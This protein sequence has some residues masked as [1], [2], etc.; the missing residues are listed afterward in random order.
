MNESITLDM[1]GTMGSAKLVFPEDSEMSTYTVK[2]DV[3]FTFEVNA[4]SAD[5]AA[6]KA[7]YFQETMKHSWGDCK[8]V[9]WVDSYPIKEII[10]RELDV[11]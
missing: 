9:S 8:D 11:T 7:K 2:L 10:E 3:R 1:P 5:A 6:K 4:E